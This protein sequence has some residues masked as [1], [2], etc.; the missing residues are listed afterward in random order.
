MTQRR[1][2]FNVKN[3]WFWSK[4]LSENLSVYGKN[5]AIKV[6]GQEDIRNYWKGFLYGNGKET[7]Q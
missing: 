6:G 5:S 7:R 1:D 2:N 3:K 4:F